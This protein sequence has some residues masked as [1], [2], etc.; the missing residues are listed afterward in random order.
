MK[1]KKQTYFL[2]QDLI[3]LLL[4]RKHLR[5]PKKS[6]K[7][8]SVKSMEVESGDKLVIAEDINGNTLLCIA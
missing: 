4:L 7:I 2:E 6:L 1:Q 3:H 5:I 8:E